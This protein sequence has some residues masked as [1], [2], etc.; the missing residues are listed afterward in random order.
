MDYLD[1]FGICEK[2]IE[3]N[4]ERA[5]MFAEE[6]KSIYSQLMPEAKKIY[7][8]IDDY[9][10][11]QKTKRACRFED[12]DITNQIIE[13]YFWA[14]DDMVQN[15]PIK[16][17]PLEFELYVNTDDSQICA[18]LDGGETYKELYDKYDL[19]TFVEETIESHMLDALCFE[20]K[21]LDA[22]L[23][24]NE[25]LRSYIMSDLRTANINMSDMAEFLKTDE[26]SGEVKEII[27]DVVGCHCPK[28]A[29]RTEVIDR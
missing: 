1:K 22:L 26:L 2:A 23:K 5:A 3:D 15:N 27:K 21:K 4:C 19:W 11:I 12:N 16:N 29:D 9:V 13:A 25:E 14:M 18:S 28:Y 20:D 7:N 24:G 17:L 6:Y 8:S 10:E